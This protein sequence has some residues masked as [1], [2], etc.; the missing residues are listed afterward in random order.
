[1]M[2]RRL[3]AIT[4]TI[5]T[6]IVHPS[7]AHA[8]RR[9]HRTYHGGAPAMEAAIEATWPV[10]LHRQAKDVAWCESGGSASAHRPGSQYRGT[11]QLG[12]EIWRTFGRG[13]VWS[14]RDNS[15]SAYRAYQA[16]GWSP[17]SC[18]P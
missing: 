5:G 8:M 1:M 3:A 12:H 9:V 15:A 7:G 13:N 4:A 6:L 10:R 14:S 2:A 16:R 18:T 17:W 11:F